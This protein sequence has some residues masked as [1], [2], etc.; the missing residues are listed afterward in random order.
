MKKNILIISILLLLQLAAQSQAVVRME[1]PEQSDKALSA[2]TL[3]DELLP[4]DIPIVLGPLGY[5]INGGTAPYNY[6]WLEN[7]NIISEDSMV[8]ITASAGN[9]YTLVIIDNNNCTVTI[10]V[11]TETSSGINTGNEDDE[12]VTAWLSRPAGI[13]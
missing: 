5:D 6:R 3:F 2:S 11:I 8:V 7:D 9:N 1:M 10:P 4:L 12:I 13:S